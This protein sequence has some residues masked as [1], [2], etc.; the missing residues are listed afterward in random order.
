MGAIASSFTRPD[1]KAKV[2]FHFRRKNP[3]KKT[4]LRKPWEGLV[5]VKVK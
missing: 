1:R 3:L 4:K 5:V 2:P